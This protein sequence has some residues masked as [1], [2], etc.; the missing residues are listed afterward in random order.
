MRYGLY[1]TLVMPFGLTNAPA[2]F[3]QFINDALQPF[4]DRFASAYLDDIIVYSDTLEEHRKHVRQVLEKLSENGLHLEPKKCEFF[5]KEIKY[6]GL[7]IGREGIKMDPEKVRT[8]QDWETPKKPRDVHS[9]VGFA[10]FYRRFIWDY[11]GIV[12]PLTELTKKG[13]LW[14]WGQPQQEA[15]ERLKQAFVSAPILARF[16]FDRDIVVETDTSDY[17]STRVLSQYGEDAV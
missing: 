14:K 3:Q 7:I 17:V 8:V 11:S 13:V 15:F 12:Q 6:L 10:K 2:S 9:F 16:D 4:L 1:E 5:R